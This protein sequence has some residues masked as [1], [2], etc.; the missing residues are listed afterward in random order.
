MTPNE[1][2]QC[3]SHRPWILPTTPWNYYQ[4]WNNVVFLHW[5]VDLNELRTFV[6]TELEI[7]LFDGSAWVSLVAF[8]MENVSPRY[9]PDFAPI[10]TFDEINIRTYVKHQDRPGVYFL[11]IEGGNRLSCWIAKHCPGSPIVIPT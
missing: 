2:L 8:T 5:Q 1:I 11:S 6:P 10:S 3:S 9:L 4:E 7:D